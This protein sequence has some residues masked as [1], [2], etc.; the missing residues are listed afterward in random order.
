MMGPKKLST[1]RK[2]LRQSLR[3]NGKDP[4]QWLLPVSGYLNS[5]CQTLAPGKMSASTRKAIAASA[6][7]NMSRDQSTIV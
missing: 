6:T 7:R 5:P 4:I 3:K 1:I 2:E